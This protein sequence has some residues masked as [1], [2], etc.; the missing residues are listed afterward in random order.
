MEYNFM[1]E[2]FDRAYKEDQQF[3][4]IFGAF[5]L[6]AMA[7][8]GLGLFGLSSFI[9]IQRSKEIGVR[10]VL[11]ASVVNIVRLISRDFLFLVMVAFLLGSP[12]VYFIMDSWLS[13]YAFRI[14]LPIWILPIAGII[15][16]FI[17]ICTVGYQTARAARA[18]PVKTLRVD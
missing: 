14:D 15:L 2:N 10:K 18:N 16:L 9:A 1:D 5:S 6:L 3:G 4:S 12:L 13:N 7:I 11:G 17:T 8:A